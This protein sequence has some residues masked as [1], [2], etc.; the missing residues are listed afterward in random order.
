MQTKSLLI[1]PRPSAQLT[2]RS[3]S[4][5]RLEQFATRCNPHIPAEARKEALRQIFNVET[6]SLVEE[7][8]RI[9]RLVTD[10]IDVEF[11]TEDGSIRGDKVWLIDFEN[12][13]NNDWLVTNQFTAVEGKAL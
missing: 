6:P 10:G 1:A 11:T 12:P 2:A 13:E 7:N 9:H 4:A 3:F 5:W 8:R